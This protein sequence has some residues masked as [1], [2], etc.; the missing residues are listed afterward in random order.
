MSIPCGTELMRTGD[1]LA[2]E[3]SPWRQRTRQ[4]CHSK[5]CQAGRLL[6]SQQAASACET[7]APSPAITAPMSSADLCNDSDL[8]LQVWSSF[9]ITQCSSQTTPGCSQTSPHPRY[10]ILRQLLWRHLSGCPE[11]AARAFSHQK[12]LQCTEPLTCLVLPFPQH[13][14][15]QHT[16]KAQ[17]PKFC[18]GQNMGNTCHIP[19]Q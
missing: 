2:Q 12:S 18:T 6:T 1:L 11:R 17:G 16:P 3:R 14:L 4:G 15:V 13:H 8:D 5:A 9:V 10:N 7:C 19:E